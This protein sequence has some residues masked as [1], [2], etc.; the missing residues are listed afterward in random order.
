MC[1]RFA[2]TE[3]GASP[4]LS[5]AIGIWCFSARE[6]PFPPGRDDLD[7]R[8][9]RIGRQFEPHL[10]VAFAGRTVGHGVRPGL[11]GDFHQPFRDQRARDGGA[12]KVKTL[13]LRI[14]GSHGKS[15]AISELGVL[16]EHHEA[17]RGQPL[18]RGVV[19]PGPA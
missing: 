1:S 19:L 13:E 2:S 6:I 10:V 11:F 14:T 18:H 3:N 9:E 4:R 15:P 8:V 16:P 5:F 7:L 17:V 12:E